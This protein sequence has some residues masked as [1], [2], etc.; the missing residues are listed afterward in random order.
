[1]LWMSPLSTIGSLLRFVYFVYFD[2]LTLFKPSQD[3][4]ILTL[5]CWM[6]TVFILCM[7]ISKKSEGT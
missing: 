5:L 6:Q 4:Q 1:M 3:V 2:I 7:F